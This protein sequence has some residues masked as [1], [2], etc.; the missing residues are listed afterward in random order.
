[1]PGLD[2][3]WKLLLCLSTVCVSP[4]TIIF[5]YHRLLFLCTM[6]GYV[7]VLTSVSSSTEGNMDSW[8]RTRALEPGTLPL[9]GCATLKK[10]LYLSGPQVPHLENKHSNSSHL[11]ELL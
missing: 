4:Q 5:M 2:P 9:A 1:M 3:K 10:L 8:S 7:L 6:K 11:K